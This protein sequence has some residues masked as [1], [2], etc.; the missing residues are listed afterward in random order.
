M[1]SACEEANSDDPRLNAQGAQPSRSQGDY[2]DQVLMV[3]LHALHARL[4]AQG[5]E[6]RCAIRD[7]GASLTL[8]TF[9]RSTRL[10][11]APPSSRCLSWCL[12]FRRPRTTQMVGG[13]AL[14]RK[15]SMAYH[16][17]HSRSV[18]SLAAWRIG[19]RALNNTGS[20]CATGLLRCVQRSAPT[21][22]PPPLFFF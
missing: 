19:Q 22:A 18:P 13:Q 5:A 1:R 15:S 7:S 10:K 4:H 12:L 11:I 17:P 21:P 2:Y 8:W 6:L 3:G 20:G 9:R 14:L 16:T